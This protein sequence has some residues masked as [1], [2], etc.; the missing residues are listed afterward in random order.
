MEINSENLNEN[1]NKSLKLNDFLNKILNNFDEQMEKDEIFWIKFFSF[2]DRKLTRGNNDINYFLTSVYTIPKHKLIGLLNEMKAK[3][4]ISSFFIL[5]ELK[6]ILE[7]RKKE[8]LEQ[9]DQQKDFKEGTSFCSST[10]T[11]V[12]T[13]LNIQN[14]TFAQEQKKFLEN[15]RPELKQS[16]VLLL[17]IRNFT[18][19]S[20][21]LYQIFTN[22]NKDIFLLNVREIY[23]AMDGWLQKVTQAN[24]KA[25]DVIMIGILRNSPTTLSFL[26]ENN[27]YMSTKFAKIQDPIYTQI[28]N[29]TKNIYER[30]MKLYVKSV[31]SKAFSAFTDVWFKIKEIFEQTDVSTIP[32]SGQYSKTAFLKNLKMTF[33]MVS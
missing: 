25:K 30:H 7:S 15:Y 8:E 10:M 26:I 6:N 33:S 28:S 9:E 31:F 3:S 19:L 22:T 32:L 27:Y 4:S 17:P 2:D 23:D 13:A 5:S 1:Q 21:A 12:Y 16:E 14:N 24:P 11:E 20:I 29:D 18:A